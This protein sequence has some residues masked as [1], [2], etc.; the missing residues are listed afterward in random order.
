[1]NRIQS[2]A[3]SAWDAMNRPVVSGIGPIEDAETLLAQCKRRDWNTIIRTIN[4]SGMSIDEIARRVGVQRRRTVQHWRDDP[5][6]EPKDSHARK[7]M[8]LYRRATGG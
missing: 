4:E 6:A 8:V 1:M 3:K 7:L 2:A 5:R